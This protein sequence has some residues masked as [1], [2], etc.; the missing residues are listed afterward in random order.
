MVAMNNLDLAMA[1]LK[2]MLIIVFVGQ[3]P[4]M[5]FRHSS[6]AETHQAHIA[7]GAS[8]GRPSMLMRFI[9]S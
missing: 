3:C 5:T 7:A 4:V 6:V 8:Y 1:N 9:S 2:Y